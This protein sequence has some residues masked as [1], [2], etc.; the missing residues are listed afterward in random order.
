MNNTKYRR[1]KFLFVGMFIILFFA[2]SGLVMVLWNT[3]LPEVIG[4]KDLNFWQAMGILVLSKILFGGFRKCGKDKGN[5]FQGIEMMKRMK[6]MTPE[7]R[8]IFKTKL[9]ER[10]GNRGFCSK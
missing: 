6:H 7:E 9:K 10:Y 1:K 5:R 2:V 8:E 3:I 4:V